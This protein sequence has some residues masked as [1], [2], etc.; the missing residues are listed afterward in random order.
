MNENDW[1]RSHVERCLQDAWDVA[2][3][4]RDGD[5]DYPFRHGTAAGFVSPIQ[6]DRPSFLRVWA[7]AVVGVKRSLKLL[8]ELNEINERALTA[9]VYWADCSIIV[10]QTLSAEA[11]SAESLAQACAAVGTMAD[12]FGLLVASAFGGHTVYDPIGLLDDAAN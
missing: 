12:D 10:E 3:V 4:L 9:H 11:V 7:L 6:Q 8:T 1:F 2:G 5:G